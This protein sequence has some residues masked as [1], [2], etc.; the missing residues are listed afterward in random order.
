MMTGRAIWM[1]PDGNSENK[2]RL[3]EKGGLEE[4]V[5]DGMSS[6]KVGP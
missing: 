6:L 1:F 2:M 5:A 4:W 3:A